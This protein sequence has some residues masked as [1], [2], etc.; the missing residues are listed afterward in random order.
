MNWFRNNRCHNFNS[1][2][3]YWLWC[4]RCR[5]RLHNNWCFRHYWRNR[6]W[7]NFRFY[8]FRRCFFRSSFFRRSFLGGSLFRRCSS[9]SSTFTI[10]I[11]FFRSSFFGR[12]F[13]LD[14][15]VFLRLHIAL[16]SFTFG[17]TTNAICLGI[18]H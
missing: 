8:R 9:I 17:F 2:L 1:A 11:Y 6:R 7:G 16:E 12:G 13:F 4:H 18:L 10:S 3:H 15:L 14:R 5:R